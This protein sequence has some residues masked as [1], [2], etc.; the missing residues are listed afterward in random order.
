MTPDVIV[1]YLDIL[2]EDLVSEFET[3]LKGTGAKVA[4][5]PRP[6]G[7][8]AGIEWL[9]PT[10]IVVYLTQRYLGTLLQEAAKEHYPTIKST[11]ARL[12]RRTTGAGREI[13]LR[14]VA[15]SPNKIESSEPIVLSVYVEL[16]SGRKA[17]FCFEHS[18]DDTDIKVAVEAFLELIL[19]HQGNAPG[20]DLTQAEASTPPSR[21]APMIVRFD[22]A[23]GTWSVWIPPT[24]P[25]P[26]SPRGGE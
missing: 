1:S 10:A 8:Q 17:K 18:L 25:N 19:Q 11:L 12:V 13:R 6:S 4:T 15:S 16:R 9:L 20:D 14:A 23:T 2:P 7:P 26:D 22:P 21:W 3:T 24:G 5:R